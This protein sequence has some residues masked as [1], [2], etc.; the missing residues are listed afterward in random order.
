MQASAWIDDPHMLS[1]WHLAPG[2]PKLNMQPSLFLTVLGAQIPSMHLFQ[3]EN[4]AGQHMHPM[5]GAA[6]AGRSACIIA[7]RQREVPGAHLGAKLEGP[8]S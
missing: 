5:Q 8:G 3:Y 6:G 4:G 2:V 1:D 7:A